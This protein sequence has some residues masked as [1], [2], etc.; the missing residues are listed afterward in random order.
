ML[1]RVSGGSDDKKMILDWSMSSRYEK[2]M[3]KWKWDKTWGNYRKITGILIKLEKIT[4]KG[5][6]ERGQDLRRFQKSYR[7]K[8]KSDF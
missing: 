2:I 1:Y 6:R 4:K 8:L 5:K 3:K 7:K